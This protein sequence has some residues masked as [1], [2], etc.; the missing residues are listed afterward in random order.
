VLRD[1]KVSPLDLERLGPIIGPDRRAR[2]L[3]GSARFRD[4]MQGR[5]LWTVNST[6]TGGGVAEMLQV[7]VGYAVGSGI[8]MRWVVIGGDEEFF[9][10]TKRLHHRLH[11]MPGDGGPLGEAEMQHYVDTTTRAATELA[12]RVQRGDIVLLHDPQTAGMVPA[13]CA[14]GAVV[15][16]RCHIGT[17]DWNDCAEDGW[18]FLRAFVEQADALIFTRAAYAPP[19]SPAQAM[20]VIPPSIDPFSPKNQ[21]LSDDTVAAIVVRAGL[22]AGP[23]RAT[24]AGDTTFLRRDGSIGEVTRAV[25]LVTDG[26]LPSMTTPLVVQVSRWDPLKDMSGVMTAFARIAPAVDAHLALVGPS[27]AGVADDPE[28]AAVLAACT[29]Q[30]RELPSAIRERVHLLSLPMQ[31]VDE[32]AAMVNAIQRHASVVVQKS[33]AEGFGLTVTE[34]MWK[35]RPVVASCVG[36]IPEQIAPGTGVLLPDPADLDAAA[37]AI[38]GLLADDATRRRIGTAAHEHVRETFVGDLHVLRF[39]ALFEQLLN[40]EP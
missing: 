4:D 37:S 5:T 6:A 26:R 13:L 3:A 15:V 11:G 7:L 19:W 25:E 8:D 34:A 1:V 39:V 10:I 29:A 24:V 14:R 23:D 21:E 36:G 17:D 12:A 16:W 33:L 20:M 22:V 28:G 40:R 9:R 38:L 32:N 35:A 27:V 30:W 2:M 31:D 18:R